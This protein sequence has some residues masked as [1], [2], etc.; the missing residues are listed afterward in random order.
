MRGVW[1]SGLHLPLGHI[2]K[3]GSVLAEHL[4]LPSKKLKLKIGPGF[5]FLV[6]S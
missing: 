5:W 6:L 3:Q 1:S 2:Q 4:M